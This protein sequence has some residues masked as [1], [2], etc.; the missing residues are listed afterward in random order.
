MPL[1]T[2]G[3]SAGGAEQAL[4]QCDANPDPKGRPLTHRRT[5]HP[6]PPVGGDKPDPADQSCQTVH[7]Q[8]C[9]GQ[10]N[11][12]GPVSRCGRAG[13]SNSSARPT[14][15]PGAAIAN[16]WRAHA[17]RYHRHASYVRE[18]QNHEGTSTYVTPQRGR[19]PVQ[20]SSMASI[21]SRTLTS[22]SNTT[23]TS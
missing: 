12:A 11:A 5:R 14:V 9:T 4:D 3:I 13:S 20:L 16:T 15:A 18:L 10:A 7:S 6:S 22:L 2:R 19:R 17:S 21:A 1:S 8:I 23:E